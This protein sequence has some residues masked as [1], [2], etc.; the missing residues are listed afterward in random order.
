MDS[1]ILTLHNSCD[2]MSLTQNLAEFEF[3]L[4]GVRL[5]AIPVIDLGEAALK[6]FKYML[7]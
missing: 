2:L 1:L 5:S 6:F 7:S 3:G 4:T